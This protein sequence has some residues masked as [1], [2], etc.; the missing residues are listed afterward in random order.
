MP[1][2]RGHPEHSEGS[3]FDRLIA[4][5]AK[6]Y[7]GDSRPPADRMWSRIE[8]DVSRALREPERSRFRQW[9]W[10]AAGAGI[11]AALVVGIAIGRGSRAPSPATTVASNQPGVP[12]D[13]LRSAMMQA[14]MLAHLGQTEIFLTEVRADLKA[15]RENP[16]RAE[17]SR[18]LLARTRLIMASDTRRA[19]TV[20]RLLEDL[21][22]V[23]AA[24]SA[25][26][27]SGSRRSTDTRLLDEQLEE[28]TVLPRIRTV[29]PGPATSE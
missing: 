3:A 8:G 27:D 9:T 20:E 25:L 18:A 10:L 11:A 24:I 5:E 29:L 4:R 22:L 28:G 23:L 2:E 15:G 21:E 14:V 16:E 17:R 6:G 7:R 19:P 13:S 12:A 26:P 1:D